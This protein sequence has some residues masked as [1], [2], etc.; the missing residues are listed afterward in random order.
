MSD[1][2]KLNR[3]KAIL[4]VGMG[5]LVFLSPLQGEI[6]RLEISA[7]YF[8]PFEKSFRDIYGQSANYG[9][10]IG[11]SVWKNLEFH[12]DVH[13]FYKTGK[14][15]YTQEDTRIILRPVGANLRYVFLKKKVN[16]YA[17]AGLTYNFFEERNPIGTVKE[18]KLGFSV[19]TGGYTRFKGL[20]KV[21]KEF[22]INIYISYNYCQMKPA[23][24]GFNIG[25]LD[26]GIA[27]GFAF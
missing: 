18:N 2:L 9:L 23:D 4:L 25:G 12:F 1:R 22:I 19:R 21:M 5:L 15:T 20:Q 24:I 26:L 16:L 7:S 3:A 17:G 13:Y 11:R 6:A 27:L 10:S 14:L 8:Y